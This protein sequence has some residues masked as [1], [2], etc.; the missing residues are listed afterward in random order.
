MLRATSKG[1]TGSD[2]LY[3]AIDGYNKGFGI[4][5]KHAEVG[6]YSLETSL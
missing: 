5:S 4:I 2:A 6:H 1:L 3:A